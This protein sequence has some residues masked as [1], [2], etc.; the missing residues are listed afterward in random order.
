VKILDKDIATARAVRT[1]DVEH[2]PA[3]HVNNQTGQVACES[4]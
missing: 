4:D 2:V 3:H 1:L